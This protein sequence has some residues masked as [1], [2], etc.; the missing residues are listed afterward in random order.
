M[1]SA[2]LIRFRH[3]PFQTVLLLSMLILHLA[4]LLV[5][6]ISPSF[7]QRKKQHTPLIV[8]TVLAKPAFKAPNREKEVSRSNPNPKPAVAKSPPQQQSP[9]VSKPEIK[10]QELPK[11]SAKTKP[12]PLKKNPPPQNPSKISDS[13]LKELQESIAKIENK[14][15]KAAVG[16]RTPPTARAIAPI[17]LQI[18]STAGEE[19]DADAG[20]YTDALISHLHR[21]LSLPDYGE[22]KIQLSLRQDGTVAKGV[23]LKAQSV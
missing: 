20:D 8:K 9:Q 22:V 14:G 18:D 11:P 12:P 13:L 19:V 23:V 5:L 10:K 4:F 7:A 21:H 2:L 15:D 3:N 16:K 6:L 1:L 17:A